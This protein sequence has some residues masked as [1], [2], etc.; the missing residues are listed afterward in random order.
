MKTIKMLALFSAVFAVALSSCGGDGSGLGGSDQGADGVDQG[1]SAVTPPAAPT[2]LV[3]TAGDEQVTLTW[4]AVDGAES[5]TILWKTSAGVTA[6]DNVIAAAASPYTHASLA[7]GTTYSYAVVAVKGSVD[8]VLSNEAS[9]AVYSLPRAFVTSVRGTG[10]LGGWAEA[11]GTTGLA[12]GD[13]ICQKLAANA[14]L[15]GTFKALLSSDTVDAKDRIAT[16][17]PWTRVDKV[18]VAENKSALFDGNVNA[19]I[20]LTETGA[21]VS[22]NVWTGSNADGTTY[23]KT[24]SDWKDESAAQD[25]RYGI[26]GDAASTWLSID[27]DPCAS[28]FS[29]YCLED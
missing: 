19:P 13:A 29:L 27:S 25:G 5:Y 12:A 10:K 16:D 15:G 1:Q 28:T 21:S 8:S 3:A 4:D 18:L 23:S 7:G 11:S 6:S 17:G 20:D 14:G 26:A 9:A 2:N 24:C 22:T